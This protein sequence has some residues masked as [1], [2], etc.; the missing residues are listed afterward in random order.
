MSLLNRFHAVRCSCFGVLVLAV[1]LSICPSI[2]LADKMDQSEEAALRDYFSAN[3]L[4]NRGLYEL[5]SEEY[6]KFLESHGSHEKAPVA[7]YGLSVCLYRLKN[8]E[9]AASELLLLLSMDNPPYEAEAGT[10]LGQCLLV[11][12]DAHGAAAAF[13]E[14]IQLGLKNDLSDDAVAGASEAYYLA[15]SYEESI[16][17]CEL[18][19]KK[20]PA[21][22]LRERVAF[23]HG[24][25]LMAIRDYEGASGY[26]QYVLDKH[27]QGVFAMQAEL[28][29]AQC[30][31][32]RQMVPQA[33]A[34][35]EAVLR[36]GSPQYV[37]DAT[38]GLGMLALQQNKWELAGK[39]F[40][41]LLEKHSDSPLIPKAHFCRGR[42]RFE[43]GDAA[44]AL[45]HFKLAEGKLD[46]P[47][48]VDDLAYWMAKCHLR[49]GDNEKAAEAFSSAIEGFG[50]SDLIAQMHY[51]RAIALVRS[52]SLEKG[53][54]ALHAFID[55]FP[56]DG[57]MPDA[58]HLIAAQEHA[59]EKHDRA[60]EYCEQF[61]KQFPNHPLGPSVA[62]IAAESEF[63]AG[64]FPAAVKRYDSFLKRF[65]QDERA[66]KARYRLGVALYKLD[67]LDEA[68]PHLE[69]V[70]RLAKKDEL[71]RFSLLALGDMA[72]RRSEWKQA[73][74]YLTAY[75]AEG[76]SVPS[77]DDALLKLGLALRRQDSTEPALIAF[78]RIIEKHSDSV[79]RLQ[80]IFERGQVLVAL[81]RLGEAKQSFERVLS[82]GGD[83][84]FKALAM[85]HLGSL[86][87][88]RD[89][90][91]EAA[92]YFD[93]VA[94]T[95]SGDLDAASASFY[96][97]QALLAAEEYAEAAS[98]FARF[99]KD[100]MTH[101]HAPMAG[102][103]LAVAL[104]R[105]DKYPEAIRAIELVE[106]RF[107]DKL[108]SLW[109]A[110]VLYE[111]AWC[112]RKTDQS[113]KSAEVY[114]R[115]LTDSPP[116]QVKV[117]A[118]L[119]LAGIEIE[120]SRFDAAAELLKLQRQV[121]QDTKMELPADMLSQQ[122]YQL[123]VC[124]FELK[125]Y[126]QAGALFEEF[127]SKFE[128]NPLI[129]SASFFCG[130][131]M[132]H[133]GKHQRAAI[134]FARVAD[135][136]QNDKTYAPSLL[137]LG[138]CYALLTKWSES[139]SVLKTYLSR[140]AGSDLWFQAQFGL[141]WALEHQQ[142]YADA[143]ETYRGVVDRHKGETAARAQF[144]VGE[145][146]FAQ[147]QYD[148]AVREFLKVDILYDYPQWSA[149]A[150]YEAGQ[151]FIKLG[152][153]VEA[154]N[155]FK[156]VVKDHNGTKWAQMAQQRLKR[157]KSAAPPGRG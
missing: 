108:D 152:K 72:F 128:D 112:L 135:H 156:Q 85:S 132:Y 53:I 73:Q 19:A 149:A 79:H 76:D 114:R 54:Q 49:M 126:E 77:A 67:R 32:H 154:R 84:R 68:K 96:R 136:H 97:G 8:Y 65:A 9:R 37:A 104:S 70:A 119:D 50:G 87:M 91:D 5:A 134:H 86:A 107:F 118:L 140:F 4:L 48:L 2:A 30:L 155:H 6:G 142:R 82:E 35:Y 100:N 139:E 21:N 39:L 124:E 1:V 101:E 44:R 130:E 99:L 116:A 88:Q 78:E 106:K 22:P 29:L 11:L 23:F 17:R 144:Q 131:S 89:D 34:R 25:S 26:L 20:W 148:E 63:L 98:V 13:D 74:H 117:H 47:A 45:Q 141:G 18:F 12:D 110:N 56:N 138:E 153:L 43:L 66:D 83:S 102:A 52:G 42:S 14:V 81:D 69:A 3:G 151:C 109:R 58:L 143:V 90:F 7:R 93:S 46:D 33:A 38:F 15:G 92:K 57:M 27:R 64:K 125:R 123:A 55:R 24:V 150:L 28:L 137:R 75:L 41:N 122:I 120:T 51:D 145:C 36:Q 133:R 157:L 60:I 105:L 16:N 147:Q 115:L 61:A 129:A 111:K 10:M 80:A 146:L 62:M 94:N 121:I 71:Y 103:Q 31:H 113:E 127:I 40:D 95:D 59:R